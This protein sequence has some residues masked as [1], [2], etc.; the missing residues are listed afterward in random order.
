MT[1]TAEAIK[2]GS[3]WVRSNGVHTGLRKR[4]VGISKT[5]VKFVEI[6]G[7]NSF[8][9]GK[10][11]DQPQSCS[12]EEFLG[13]HVPAS[14]LA[15]GTTNGY[16]YRRAAEPKPRPV[17]KPINYTPQRGV[18]NVPR[19]NVSIELVT[20]DMAQE[21]I[22][23]GG[24]NRKLTQR[25]VEALAAALKRGEG[26]LTYEPIVFDDEGH[27]INGQ[28]RLHAI[29]HS[30]VPLQLMVVRGAEPEV[31]D[32]MDT[33]RSRTIGDIL[34]IHGHPSKDATAATVRNL[35][36]YEAY[37]RFSPTVRESQ[38]MVNSVTTLAYLEEHPEVHE[39]VLLGDR[40]RGAGLQGGIGVWAALATIWLRIS[41]HEA[42]DFIEQLIS[43]ARLEHGSPALALRN[44]CVNRESGEFSKSGKGREL[45]GAM[46]IKAWNSFRRGE[47]V[48]ILV[49]RGD[50]KKPEPFPQAI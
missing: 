16:A 20:P 35:M 44:R 17:E 46:A 22:D 34:S 33:G 43:G 27:V 49:W 12:I 4:V 14:E 18:I 32:V 41:E 2:S 25:R 5:R 29:V 45:L 9:N 50:A 28:H 7:G 38:Y 31:F 26:R 3:E 48:Q 39:G 37:G 42:R 13:A 1:R 47:Q 15:G 21:W 6:G 24:R 8:G 30:G 23:R 10:V 11:A 40:I 19:G 36:F